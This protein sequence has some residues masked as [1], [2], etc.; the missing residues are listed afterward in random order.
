MPPNSPAHITLSYS[1]TAGIVAVAHGEKYPWA[2]TALQLAGF[3]RRD[4]GAYALATG[5]AKATRDVIR[6][7]LRTARRHQA[8]VTVSSR[9]YFG[10]VAEEIAA[11][12]P[13]N[14]NAEVAIHSHPVWQHDLV[15]LLWDAG[16][17]IRAVEDER[18]PYTA[19]LSDGAGIELLLVERP[20]HPHD[21]LVGAFATEG[22]DDNSNEPIAPVSITVPSDVQLAARAIADQFLPAYRQALHARRLEAV[23]YGLNSLREEYETLMAMKESGRYSDATVLDPSHLPELEEQFGDLAW[24]K[25]RNYLIHAPALLETCRPAQTAWPEDAAT[26]ERLHGAVAQGADIIAEWGSLTMPGP[27]FTLHSD[28]AKAE[29]KARRNTL[30]RP[31]IET[32]IADGDAFLRQ[33]RAAVPSPPRPLPLRDHGGLALP[34][35]RPALPSTA[36][37]RR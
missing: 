14:W 15:P 23:T 1:H 37:A 35:A 34:P 33:A 16:E 31:V 18:L 12:L 11:H 10:E 21:Y 24:Y 28:Q 13:G 30:I 20:G 32:W 6:T 17:L 27:T 7:L 4:D 2:Q 29:A 3:Q 26:L 9:R 5:D 36:P 19:V 8:A 22:F 25:L